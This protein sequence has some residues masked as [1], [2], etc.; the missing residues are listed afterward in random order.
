MS[1]G[2]RITDRLM[3]DFMGIIMGMLSLG[4]IIYGMLTRRL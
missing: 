4:A 1:R 3:R 2:R